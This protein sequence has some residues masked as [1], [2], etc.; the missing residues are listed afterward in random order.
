[1]PEERVARVEERAQRADR[2]GALEAKS[3]YCRPDTDIQLGDRVREG[4]SGPQYPVDG[5][6]AADTN[7]FT[8]WR[9][10]REVPLARAAG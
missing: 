10:V 9:P 6:P 4:T 3:L 1:M 5:I 2:T 8:N 7:P